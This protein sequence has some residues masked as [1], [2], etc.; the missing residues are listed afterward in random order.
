MNKFDVGEMLEIFWPASSKWEKVNYRG[1]LETNGSAVVVKDGM[2]LVVKM[3]E[4]RR[5]SDG[6]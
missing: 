1:R 5:V 3:D 6:K 2:Q 4:L